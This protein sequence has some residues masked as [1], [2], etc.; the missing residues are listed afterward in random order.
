GT[1]YYL[2]Y[3]RNA[4]EVAS[5]TPRVKRKLS[6]E[7]PI[8]GIIGGLRGAVEGGTARSA[9]QQ[10]PIAGKTGTCSEYGT[11]LGWFGAFT[12]VGRKLVVVVFLMGRQ[13]S[14]PRA[15]GIAG[16]IYRQLSVENYLVEPPV[17]LRSAPPARPVTRSGSLVFKALV[18]ILSSATLILIWRIL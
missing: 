10:D 16:E 8:S 9:R 4:Q 2:Q 1:L 3:P 7:Q 18:L 6:I 14:G 13:A 5:L 12:S 11:N 15:A 17:V